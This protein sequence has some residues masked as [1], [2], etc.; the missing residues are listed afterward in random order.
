MQRTARGERVANRVLHPRVGGNDEATGSPRSQP[1]HK[2]R[3]PV[4]LLPEG[5]FAKQEDPEEGR[6]DKEG[7]GSFHSQ[8]LRD[9]IT[10]K[11]REARPV[12]A[13]LKLHRDTRHDAYNKGDGEESG[14]EACTCVVALVLAPQVQRFEDQDEQGQPH[15]ELRKEIMKGDREGKL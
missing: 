1:H 14:P 2:R 6:F 9:D 8:G 13:E 12:G 11:D 5:A 7:K 10:R 3:K 15:G 4:Y